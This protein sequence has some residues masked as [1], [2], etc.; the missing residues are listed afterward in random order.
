MFLSNNMPANAHIKAS[1]RD[2]RESKR[3]L[4]YFKLDTIQKGQVGEG[5]RLLSNR[6]KA[7]NIK[8]RFI[9]PVMINTSG[10]LLDTIY[11]EHIDKPWFQQGFR[12]FF[13]GVYKYGYMPPIIVAVMLEMKCGH[14]EDVFS[15]LR[16]PDVIGPLDPYEKNENNM[17]NADLIVKSVRFKLL[18]G[19]H[20]RPFDDKYCPVLNRIHSSSNEIDAER[21]LGT[22]YLPI[23]N[24][25][26]KYYSSISLFALG[27]AWKKASNDYKVSNDESRLLFSDINV[28]KEGNLSIISSINGNNII[29]LLGIPRIIEL[30]SQIKSLNKLFAART[31][32]FFAKDQ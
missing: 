13:T 23:F 28:D 17:K 19:D 15:V 6:L 1:I 16:A 31:S 9:A 24:E 4:V 22:I 5:I 29:N 26:S 11:S 2:Y 30:Y 14:N 32:E 10:K 8:H 3:A 25:I 12:P 27:I 20:I 21:E 18:N 7:H